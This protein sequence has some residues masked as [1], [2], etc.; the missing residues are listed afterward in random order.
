METD[1]DIPKSKLFHLF[2]QIGDFEEALFQLSEI[3]ENYKK[4]SEDYEV[5]A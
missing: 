5:E 3:S 2:Y 4:T 1:S